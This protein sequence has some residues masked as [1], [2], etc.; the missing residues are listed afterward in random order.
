MIIYKQY[1]QQE[2]DNQYNNRLHVPDFA[3]Y[4]ER[5]DTWSEAARQKHSYIK[6]IRYGDHPGE[7]LDIFPSGKQG[8]KVL[9]FIHGGYW[10]LFD[11]TT[12]HFVAAAFLPYDITTIV[13]NYPLAPA[14]AMDD[15][16]ASCRKAVRWLQQHLVD[17]NADPQQVY[18]A[19]HSAGAHLATMLMSKESGVEIAPF[20]KG[21]C[22]LSGLYNLIPLQLSYVNAGLGMDKGTAIRNSPFNLQA[23][24][25]CPLLVAIGGAETDEF[26]DQSRELYNYWKTKTPVQ[27]VELGGLNHYSILDAL[28]DENTSLHKA[29]MKLMDK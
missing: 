20:I 13:V 9:I 6:D 10:Q 26:K 25:T 28:V 8:S 17:Y 4:I 7:C 14:A 15:I 22:L 24:Q 12:F 29:M 21:M 3:T 19:G 2:L 1:T 27:L 11:K 16:V 5:W 18:I 23:V